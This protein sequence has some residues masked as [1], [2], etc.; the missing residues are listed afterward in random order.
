MH[1]AL[2]FRYAFCIV[3]PMTMADQIRQAR[4]QLGESQAEFGRRFGV[5]QST[6]HR[7]ETDGLPN[8]G[9]ARM[10]VE[11]FILDFPDLYPADP[12]RAA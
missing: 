1:E 7:W 11:R 8:R 3:R 12:E 5:D 4:E 9:T 6:V 2:T 10:F